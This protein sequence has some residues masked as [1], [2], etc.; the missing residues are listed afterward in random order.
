MLSIPTD[1]EG[2][3]GTDQGNWIKLEEFEVEEISIYSFK[4]IRSTE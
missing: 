2:Y 1:K 3:A 4:P